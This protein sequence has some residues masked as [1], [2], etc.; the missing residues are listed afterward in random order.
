MKLMFVV[1]LLSSLAEVTAQQ[2]LRVDLKIDTLPVHKIYDFENYISKNLGYSVDLNSS[3]D[4]FESVLHFNPDS[5]KFILGLNP[6]T[7]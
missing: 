3:I 2:I 4:A 7:G 6:A 1:I 5:G